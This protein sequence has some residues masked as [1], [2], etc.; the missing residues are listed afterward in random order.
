[1][2]LIFSWWQA[3]YRVS[4]G[5]VVRIPLFLFLSATILG[6]SIGLLIATSLMLGSVSRDQGP[7]RGVMATILRALLGLI[8][9]EAWR[10]FRT[11]ENLLSFLGRSTAMV[12]RSLVSISRRLVP[13]LFYPLTIFR[14]GVSVSSAIWSGIC[15]HNIF[16]NTLTIHSGILG[17]EIG[18][19]S[20]DHVI[21]QADPFS[22]FTES[23][24]PGYARIPL[25]GTGDSVEDHPAM[26]EKWFF[27]PFIWT[28]SADNAEVYAYGWFIFDPAR[29]WMVAEPFDAPVAVG[30]HGD[31]VVIVLEIPVI[32][33]GGD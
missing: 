24:F 4:V 8:I 1:M 33:A 3:A 9:G 10:I 18:L 20:N 28:V 31:V 7:V 23:T 32:F 25:F 17:W 22:A 15:Q 30:T 19:Y 21:D 12:T 13:G 11:E 5:I 16:Q 27:D 26:S 29:G 6:L 2:R 14:G